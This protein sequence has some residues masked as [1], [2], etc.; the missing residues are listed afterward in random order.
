MAFEMHSVGSALIRA[1]GHD[2]ERNVLRIEF[3]DGAAWDYAGVDDEKFLRML[4]ADSV[5]RF[6]HT[7]IKG[8][9]TETRAGQEP[10]EDTQ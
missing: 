8:Q 6:F 3:K 9:H 7:E 2:Q 4:N 1:I 5:G 10:P